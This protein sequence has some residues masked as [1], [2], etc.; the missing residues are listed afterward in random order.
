MFNTL[1]F[2][3]IEKGPILAGVKMVKKAAKE[4]F[5]KFEPGRV[6]MQELVCGVQELVKDGRSLFNFSRRVGCLF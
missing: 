5:V 6:L 2:V 4:T 3:I 1:A